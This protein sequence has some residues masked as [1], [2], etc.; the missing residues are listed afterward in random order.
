MQQALDVVASLIKVADALQQLQ[1]LEQQPQQP[2]EAQQPAATSG[3]QAGQ[4]SAAG[5]LGRLEGSQQWQGLL[6]EA[7]ALLQLLR[8]GHARATGMRDAEA[9]GQQQ[10]EG[11]NKGEAGGA[12]EQA[13]AEAAGG[14]VAGVGAEE[15]ERRQLEAKWTA[16][17]SAWEACVGAEAP[18]AA[19]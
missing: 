11:S 8:P 1:Q 2:Q 7:Q 4:G 16:L 19:Q 17:R 13:G 12:G 14:A 10:E 5:R 18:E 6:R 15:I 3:A 9:A